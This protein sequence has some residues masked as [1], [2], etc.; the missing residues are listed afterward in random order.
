[1]Y[2]IQDLGDGEGL[3]VLRGEDGEESVA[4]GQSISEVVEILEDMDEEAEGRRVLVLRGALGR[5][6]DETVDVDRVIDE[7]REILG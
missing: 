7:L 4:F 3:D 2:Q 6:D 5:V 1:M